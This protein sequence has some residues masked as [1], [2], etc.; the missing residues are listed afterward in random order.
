M[1][2]RSSLFGIE[3]T[4]RFRVHRCFSWSLRCLEELAIVHIQ[5]DNFEFVADIIG[6]FCGRLGSRDFELNSL[7]NH[8]FARQRTRLHWAFDH[9]RGRYRPMLPALAKRGNMGTISIAWASCNP[10]V[11]VAICRLGMLTCQFQGRCTLILQWI[12]IFGYLAAIWLLQPRPFRCCRC[13]LP[14]STCE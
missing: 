2:K 5:V 3:T 1:L 11:Y 14:E 4:L 6:K 9:S 12:M 7:F 10:I 13:E 8:H